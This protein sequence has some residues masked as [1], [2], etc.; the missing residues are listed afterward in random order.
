M[1]PLSFSA[2]LCRHGR[3]HTRSARQACRLTF[4]GYAKLP[5]HNGGPFVVIH[6]FIRYDKPSFTRGAAIWA[7]RPAGSGAAY[8]LLVD[9]LGALNKRAGAT[10]GD[11]IA[12]SSFPLL[13]SLIISFPLFFFLPFK[14]PFNVFSLFLPCPFAV[15]FPFVTS[16]S[17]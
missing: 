10:D 9:M 6:P 11:G 14:C 3:R 12:S 7:K 8:P 16:I 5:R 17:Y 4:R 15:L 2:S 1:A 13:H